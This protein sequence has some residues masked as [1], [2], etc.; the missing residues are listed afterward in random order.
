MDN[1]KFE[2]EKEFT[3]KHEDILNKQE[4]FWRQKSRE[5]WLQGDCNTKSFHRS[6]IKNRNVNI[7]SKCKNIIGSIVDEPTQ[8]AKNFVDYYIDILNN[9]ECS[10]LTNQNL[11]L[12]SIPKLITKE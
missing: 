9:Y 5:M 12:E 4:I 11:M 2:K 1:D 6:T 7:I 10:N 3:H 8:I